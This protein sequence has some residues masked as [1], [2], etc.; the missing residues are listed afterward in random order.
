MS[1]PLAVPTYE[2]HQKT[3]PGFLFP[4]QKS[5]RSP[6]GSVDQCVFGQVAGW[7]ESAIADS[8]LQFP[9]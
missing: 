7:L 8:I 9:A 2:S 6:A 3:R 1:V 5:K 4:I